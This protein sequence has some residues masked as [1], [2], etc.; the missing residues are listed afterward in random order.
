MDFAHP[1][2][3]IIFFDFPRRG[4]AQLKFQPSPGVANT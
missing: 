2:I 4:Y 3:P 1:I